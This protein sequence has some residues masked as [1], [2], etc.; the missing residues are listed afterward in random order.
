MIDEPPLLLLLAYWTSLTVWNTGVAVA[1][2]V[3]DR[4][5]VAVNVGVAIAVLVA[6]AVAVRV[7]VAVAVG[8]PV[9]V[10]GWHRRSKRHHQV[11]GI[12]GADACRKIPADARGE[13]SL[14]RLN[15]IST[16]PP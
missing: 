7:G 11:I 12:D 9:G 2:G 8:K 14:E 13:S 1:V 3:A 15:P 4:V 10:G 16:G 6:V 5:A